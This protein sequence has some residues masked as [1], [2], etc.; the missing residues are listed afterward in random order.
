M[1]F[2]Q[3]KAQ[4]MKAYLKLF[5]IK[6]QVVLKEWG[7]R[8]TLKMTL[9]INYIWSSKSNWGS[10][11]LNYDSDYCCINIDLVLNFISYLKRN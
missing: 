10:Y 1:N 4:I 2:G 11:E 3:N 6:I 9:S 8:E 7:P 5:Q